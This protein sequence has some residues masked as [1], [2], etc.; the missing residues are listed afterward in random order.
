MI[1]FLA[2]RHAGALAAVLLLVACGDTTSGT[3]PSAD[4]GPKDTG[5]VKDSSAPPDDGPPTDTSPP[6]DV[7]DG[8]SDATPDTP[9]ACASP[10]MMCG[11]RCTDVQTDSMNCGMCGMACPMGR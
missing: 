5:G 11:D 4:S 7:S 1:R 10:M 2:L 8:G 3:P 9:P 6:P